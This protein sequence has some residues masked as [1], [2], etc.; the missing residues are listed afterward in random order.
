MLL[1]GHLK[2]FCPKRKSESLTNVVCSITMIIAW[3]HFSSRNLYIL[4]LHSEQ[5]KKKSLARM[6]NIFTF[7]QELASFSRVQILINKNCSPFLI[8]S[9]DVWKLCYK[10]FIGIN[11]E[12]SQK[13]Y[14]R[15]DKSKYTDKFSTDKISLPFL[16]K[17]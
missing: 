9:A 16:C 11:L 3:R 6:S 5:L 10:H 4:L 2:T 17:P 13:V 8:R 14:V 7:S 15:F 1:T 12:E